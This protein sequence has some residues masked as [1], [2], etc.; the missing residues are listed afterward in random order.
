MQFIFTK[1]RA[2]FILETLKF[3]STITQTLRQ[4]TNCAAT[5]TTLMSFTQTTKKNRT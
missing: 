1:I 2:I 5:D 4:V 3:I